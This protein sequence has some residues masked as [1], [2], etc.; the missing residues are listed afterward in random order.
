MARLTPEALDMAVR[1]LL[2]EADQTPEGY[3]AV[4]NVIK[5][6]FYSGAW[7]S[8]RLGSVIYA[9]KQFAVWNANN[10]KMQAL[11]ARVR[12]IPTANPNY[13]RAANVVQQVFADQLPDN[14]HG[15][16]HYYAPKG[17]P[18]GQ[19]PDWATGQNGQMIGS[20]IFYRLPLT[21]A[22]T[23]GTAV[24]S[25]ST[26]GQSGPAAASSTGNANGFVYGGSM[27]QDQG[28]DLRHLEPVFRARIEKLR[29]DAAAAG[30]TT[31]YTDGYRDNVS[32]GKDY[33][34]LGA[35]HLAA[36]PGQS[37]HQFG[38]AVDLV[39]D[40]PA[41]Q[42]ALVALADQPERGI[43]AGAH[44]QTPDR[45]HFQASEGKYAPLLETPGKE[46]APVDDPFAPKPLGQGGIGSEGHIPLGK[47][48]PGTPPAVSTIVPNP[49][50]PAANAQT[51]SATAP[52][53]T[54]ADEK[55]PVI[56]RM[57]TGTSRNP[58]LITAANW[59]SLGGAAPAASP[60]APAAAAPAAA[61][62][63]RPDLAQRTPL[64]QTPQ[65][66]PRPTPSAIGAYPPSTDFP[67]GLPPAAPAPAAPA[68]PAPAAPAPASAP[69]A[70]IASIRPAWGSTTAYD[71]EQGIVKPPN[72][73]APLDRRIPAITPG[74]PSLGFPAM[75]NP[76]GQQV[77]QIP[78]SM[79]ASAQ[80]LINLLFPP[81]PI[82]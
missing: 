61:P 78:G 67:T 46:P 60:S 77:S 3:Q 34:R 29:A 58:E 68:A 64:D 37:Y 66:P 6:R 81:R 45:V 76:F 11:A 26:V 7:G 10:P 63:P 65:P 39:A 25:P 75:Q 30:I 69:A 53:A 74:Q 57:T 1:T 72:P 48:P 70:P 36:A 15:A 9:P 5:N 71:V 22:N 73:N 51:V 49:N 2:G 40:N 82:G 52:A 14:T 62:Q 18:N 20:Q 38:R 16:T 42:A 12:A 32:Q 24:I 80:N 56:A 35:Q 13:Q 79:L 27:P 43:T 31:H 55:Y 50:A 59:G 33:A 19:S 44:F 23:A 41:Q 4:A 47:A 17:M 21:A 54:L 28:V 8:D